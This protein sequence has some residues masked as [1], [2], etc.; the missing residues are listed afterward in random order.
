MFRMLVTAAINKYGIEGL[1]ERYGVTLPSDTSRFQ[2]IEKS[3]NTLLEDVEYYELVNKSKF[4]K[5]PIKEKSTM[6]IVEEDKSIL[7]NTRLT[8]LQKL[9]LKL[10]EKIAILKEKMTNNIIYQLAVLPITIILAIIAGIN[11][12]RSFI[13]AGSNPI[14]VIIGIFIG[15]IAMIFSLMFKAIF[16]LI[17]LA[18]SPLVN[19]ILEKVV[20]KDYFKKM[21]IGQ[22]TLNN[23]ING[24]TVITNEM[25]SGVEFRVEKGLLGGEKLYMII[26]EGTETPDF[27]I[28]TLKK[29]ILP[30]YFLNRQSVIIT[31]ISEKERLESIFK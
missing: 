1:S 29:I 11:I 28:E 20:D 25:V 18:L 23:I 15:I 14:N 30:D 22:L 19:K 12:L 24:T 5:L 6:R 13:P 21:V 7:I 4:K 10:K 26:K 16:G 31:N 8:W 2:A 3:T 9:V 27:G 17:G